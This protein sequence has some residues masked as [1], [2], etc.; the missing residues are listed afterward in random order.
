M[1]SLQFQSQSIWFR[2]VGGSAGVLALLLVGAC[3]IQRET[4]SVTERPPVSTEIGTVEDTLSS[5]VSIPSGYDTVQAGQF[6]HGKLWPFDQIPTEHFRSTYGVD[7]DAEWRKQARGAALRFGDGCSASFVSERGLVLT[8]HHCAREAIE[9]V[10]RRRESLLERGFYA[11]SLNQERPVSDLHVD[12]LVEIEDVTAR[13]EEPDGRRAARAENRE[14]RIERI[15][16]AMTETVKKR[17]ETLR[18]DIVT[19]YGGAKYSA[20]TYRRHDDV[21]LVMAPER[22]VG[23]F[24]GESDNF[25]YPR[26]SFDIAFFRVYADDG[27]PLQP[28]YHYDW[29]LE[30]AEAGDPVFVVGNPGSTSRLETVAQLEY[31][32]DHQLTK[33][34]EVFRARRNLLKSHIANNAGTTGRYNLRNTLFS[35]ENTIKSIEG[36]L[37]GLQDPYLIARRGAALRALRDSIVKT[38]S[39]KQYERAL[40][41]IKRLQESKRI[42]ADKHGAFLTFSNV[43][44]GSRIFA[45]AVH[46]YYHDFLKMRGA[47]PERVKSIR[48][49]AEAV[50][51]WPADLERAFVTAQ[52]KEIRDAYGESHPT[53]QRLFRKRSP[54]ELASHLVEESALINSE[55]FEKLLE[56]GYRKSEDASV[57]VIEALAPLFLNANRQMEDLNRTE[58]KLNGRLSKARRAIYGD[59]IPPDA[60]FSLRISDGVVKGY[61]YNGSTAP[62]YTNFY[63]MYDRHYAHNA[64]EWSFPRRWRNP[65]SSFDLGTPFNIVSTND[66][67]G[68]NSGSPLLNEDLEVVGV[69]FD[70]NIEALPNEYLYR[71]QEARAISVDVRGIVEVLRDLYGA[72]RLLKEIGGE[73]KTAEW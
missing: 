43:T 24:G 48:E 35:L 20:Y 11:D 50:E 7:A 39:L 30:G 14:R 8:N 64:E 23:Y 27:T 44:L 32:R 28:E 1:T 9:K 63:G 70:T 49:D 42:L 58:E 12:V 31:K 6:D 68:G 72:T 71:D 15:E 53:V 25:T 2:W 36:K 33:K 21:R 45:R 47:S 46:A 41:K 62:P 73:D 5:V 54:E 52:L 56:N 51:D 67:S 37:H 38:D 66:V 55:S 16:E 18:V 10:S 34:L 19:L 40:W 29:D 22:Q 69:V 4:V 60:T 13:V 61:S 26:F 17:D 3:G 65:P 57:P 59:R